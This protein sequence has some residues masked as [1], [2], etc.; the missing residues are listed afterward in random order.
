MGNWLYLRN[1]ASYQEVV[2]LGHQL[3]FNFSHFET[4]RD[5]LEVTDDP[6]GRK[7]GYEWSKMVKVA[8][9][10]GQLLGSLWANFAEILGYEWARV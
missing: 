7:S 9:C 2:F 6:P 4:S 5:P 10:H 1:G 8:Q 3:K